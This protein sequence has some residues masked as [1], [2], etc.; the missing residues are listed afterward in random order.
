MKRFL[1]LGLLPFSVQV[2][3]FLTCDPYP[4]TGV[5]PSEFVVTVSL[6]R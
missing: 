5:Q 3:P 1:L 6:D 2:A 4:S